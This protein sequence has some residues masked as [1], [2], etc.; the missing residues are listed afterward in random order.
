MIFSG[1]ANLPFP[2]LLKNKASGVTKLQWA[3]LL[4]HSSH[5]GRLAC[6]QGLR[7]RLH[8]SQTRLDGTEKLAGTKVGLVR[9]SGGSFTV[10]DLDCSA[11]SVWRLCKNKK[12]VCN[13]NYSLMFS[14]GGVFRSA[15]YH[16]LSFALS[17]SRRIFRSWGSLGGSLQHDA[18]N[19]ADALSIIRGMWCF[20]PFV[21]AS[22]AMSTDWL[23]QEEFTW[24]LSRN[25]QVYGPYQKTHNLFGYNFS[26]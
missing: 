17:S 1:L 10:K 19:S 21:Y 5:A 11:S 12:T 2:M 9:W 14:G 25:W 8:R 24:C 16:G 4:W 18:R 7:R 23:W 13:V 20:M 6:M 22:R 3:W 26:R 15:R